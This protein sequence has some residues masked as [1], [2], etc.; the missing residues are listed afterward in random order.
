MEW[1]H[2][3]RW[4]GEAL[5]GPS[6]WSS[7]DSQTVTAFSYNWSSQSS[8]IP[9]CLVCNENEKWI[10]YFTRFIFIVLILIFFYPSY[11]PQR[12]IQYQRVSGS[13]SL[14]H[15]LHP[16]PSPTLG[17]GRRGNSETTVPKWTQ[18]ACPHTYLRFCDQ[19]GAPRWCCHHSWSCM[20]KV[21]AA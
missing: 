9:Y 1:R 10:T 2:G 12:G 3:G 19:P 5:H 6:R 7:D 4:T 13:I 8:Y 16:A 15:H 14:G 17:R 18:A 21:G 20:V 11:T